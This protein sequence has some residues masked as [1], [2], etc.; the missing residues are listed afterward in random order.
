MCSRWL[1]T[2]MPTPILCFI[3]CG[4]NSHIEGLSCT[5]LLSMNLIS[6]QSFSTNLLL[7]SFYLLSVQLM[8]FSLK[9]SL[10]YNLAD[11]YN[12]QMDRRCAHYY[13]GY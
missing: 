11:I 8:H 7:G 1:S 3:A 5:H 9:P 6:V 13:N 10:C 2:L 4:E 12:Q